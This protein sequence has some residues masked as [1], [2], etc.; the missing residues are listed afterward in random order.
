V[1]GCAQLV[2]KCD[3]VVYPPFPYLQAVGRALGHSGILLGAQDVYH[4]ANG[5][6]TGEVSAEMLVDLN[7]AVVIC[8]HSD[9]GA[10]RAFLNPEKL[11]ALKSVPDW[12]EHANSA[13][14]VAKEQYA[15]LPPEQFLTALAKENVVSQLQHLKTHPCVATRLRK[16]SLE[17][18]GW[19]Y[20]IGEGT[21][22]QYDPESEIFR[23]LDSVGEPVS[24]VA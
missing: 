10:M 21:V 24:R 13:I 12:I 23:P 22:E 3:V 17:V 5:A 4:E 14:A 1:A 20:D 8:G 11:G 19:Y 6:F 18:H 16:Q 7:V 9:C 2:Q 15:H